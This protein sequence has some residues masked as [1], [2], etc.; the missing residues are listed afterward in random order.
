M[1]I[2]KCNCK[3]SVILFELYIVNESVVSDSI[4]VKS[5][6]SEEADL[7]N[8]IDDLRRART[9]TRFFSVSKNRIL[10]S[11]K[12]NPALFTNFIYTYHEK[13]LLTIHNIL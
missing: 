13:Q 11:Y 3:P 2:K 6:K 1:K 12:L 10:T 8:G 7:S 4:V 9:T 5:E